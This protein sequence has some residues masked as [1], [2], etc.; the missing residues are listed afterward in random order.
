MV[1]I[2]AKILVIYF[3]SDICIVRLVFKQQQQFIYLVGIVLKCLN[4]L[5]PFLAMITFQFFYLG[6]F[7]PCLNVKILQ[8]QHFKFLTQT[9]KDLYKSRN[10]STNQVTSIANLLN[11]TQARHA[12]W[13]A[14]YNEA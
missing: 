4:D 7:S 5:H 6:K 8:K 9:L 13:M 10:N 12:L 11:M 2:L 14:S 1:Q 3:A